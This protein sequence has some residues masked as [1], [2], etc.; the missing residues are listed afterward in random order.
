M[1]EADPV[2]DFFEGE[3]LAWQGIYPFG[4][5]YRLTARN[6]KPWTKEDAEYYEA[7]SLGIEAMREVRKGFDE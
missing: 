7:V 6:R 5:V 4:H 3:G 1:P 2:S